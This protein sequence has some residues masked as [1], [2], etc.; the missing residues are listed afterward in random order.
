MQ[1]IIKGLLLITFN[2][3]KL[4]YKNLTQKFIYLAGMLKNVNF[5]SIF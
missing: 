5:I 1:L 2:N 4:N 3:S